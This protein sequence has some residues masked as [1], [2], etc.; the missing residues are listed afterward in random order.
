MAWRQT[1]VCT[2]ALTVVRC[3]AVDWQ[4]WTP[5]ERRAALSQ[6]LVPRDRGD[7]LNEADFADQGPNKPRA[8]A[9]RGPAKPALGAMAA[10]LR[11]T[12]SHGSDENSPHAWALP[13]S[14]S[15][16]SGGGGGGGGERGKRDRLASMHGEAVQASCKGISSKARALPLLLCSRK[17]V[18]HVPRNLPSR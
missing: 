14:D 3:T 16:R 10:A 6:V 4:D 12:A 13:R 15:F 8:I 17:H 2:A 18:E 1:R 11:R 5:E 9:L 7:V